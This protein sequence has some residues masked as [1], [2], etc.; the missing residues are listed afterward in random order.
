MIHSA[1]YTRPL[2]YALG[3]IVTLGF[4]L[5]LFSWLMQ[6][7]LGELGDMAQLLTGTA[8]LSAVA[9]YA[10]YRF[11][12]LERAPSLRLALLGI[13]TLVS[14]LAFINVWVSANLMFA[15]K[16]DLLLALVLLLFAGG[17]S[18]VLGFFLSSTLTERI[19]ILEQAARQIQQ[20]NLSVRVPI[21]GNDE[22]ASLAQTFNQAASR[23]EE[24]DYKQRELEALRRDLIAWAGHDLRTPLASIQA[25]V[26]ALA[27]RMVEDPD[28][29]QRYLRIAQRDIQSLSQLLDDLFEMAQLDAGGLPLERESA[30]LSDL[31]SDTLE[32]F[33]ELA[34]RQDIVLSGKVVPE[35]GPVYMDV[36]RIGRVLNNLITNALRHTPAGGSVHLAVRRRQHAVEVEIVDSGPGV[37]AQDIDHI[38][39]RFYR[40]DRSRNRESG[41]SGLGLAIARGIVEAHGGQIAAE[42]LPTGGARF[43][44]TLPD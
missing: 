9:G 7:S 38:F 34:K 19:H 3:I 15:S 31:V 32:S 1:R 33:S 8:M 44:F 41:G 42:N 37:P 5:I 10:A 30:Y 11:G 6:P 39:E 22:L 16:H 2:R 28:T 4:T 40:G 29:V 25:I 36:P 20:G 17:V 24:T 21:E 18:M 13:Y 14:V 35:V 23:L 27:D 43:Y 26:E 12:W